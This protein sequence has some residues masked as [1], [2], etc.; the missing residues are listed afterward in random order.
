MNNTTKLSLP[1]NRKVIDCKHR[2]HVNMSQLTEFTSRVGAGEYR[3]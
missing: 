1:N 2:H 3:V